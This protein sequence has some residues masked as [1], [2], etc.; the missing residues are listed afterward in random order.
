[1]V[2]QKESDEYQ[3]TQAQSLLFHG[4]LWQDLFTEVSKWHGAAARGARHN[5]HQLKKL[6]KLSQEVLLCEGGPGHE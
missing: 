6:T 4:K 5:L 1:M 2:E 3:G